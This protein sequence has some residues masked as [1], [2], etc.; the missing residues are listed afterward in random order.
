MN[1]EPLKQVLIVLLD[2]KASMRDAADTGVIERLDQAIEL[3]RESIDS[4]QTTAD[5]KYDVLVVLGQVL[6]KLPSIVA[7]IQLLHK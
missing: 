2:V 4:G 6:E 7:L 1:K 5:K 3:I